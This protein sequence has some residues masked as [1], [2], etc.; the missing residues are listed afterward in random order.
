MNVIVIPDTSMIVIPLIEKNGHTYL[1]PSNFSKYDNMD[2]CEGNLTFDNLITRYSSSELPSGVKSRLY[3]FSNVIDRADAAIILGKRPR[4]YERMYDSLN[5]L[6]LFGGNAC[7][8]ARSLMV[9]IVEDLN[10][11]TLKLAYPTNQEELINLI[12]RTNHFLKH[13]K[14]S[15]EDD[16][17]VD[18]TPKKDKYPV[19]DVKKILDNLI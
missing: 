1:S 6:I 19:S 13:L 12:D 10:L 7:N 8:N 14:S 17:N 18:L 16:L 4:E 9:K 15:N 5:D 3:L 2:I 11:P